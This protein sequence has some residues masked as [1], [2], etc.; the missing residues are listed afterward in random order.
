MATE[1]YTITLRAGQHSA[2]PAIRL[3]RLLK[4]ALRSFA[5]RAVDIRQRPKAGQAGKDSP[6][7]QPSAG[8]GI[9]NE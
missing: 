3:R 2:P 8:K 6:A 7:L 9:G 4:I 1:E 5:F